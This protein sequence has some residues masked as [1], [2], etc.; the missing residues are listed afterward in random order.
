M[1]EAAVMPVG[2]YRITNSTIAVFNEGDRHVAHM[3]PAG[4]IITIDSMALDGDKLVDVIWDGR[5]AMMF[6]QD[7][8]LRSE[9]ADSK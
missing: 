4:S 1:R 9:A 3:V 7:L 6:A 5:K 8:R 2:R